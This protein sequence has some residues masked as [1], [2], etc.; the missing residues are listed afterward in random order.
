MGFLLEPNAPLKPKSFFIENLV[1]A[2]SF[3]VAKGQD[4]FALFIGEMLFGAQAGLVQGVGGR[5]FFKDT[6]PHLNV[7][8][9]KLQIE[10]RNDATLAPTLNSSN[11]NRACRQVLH[12]T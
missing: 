2:I 4:C 9:K 3:G 7:L 6:S 1:L 10:L 5:V 11:T 8:E 12:H